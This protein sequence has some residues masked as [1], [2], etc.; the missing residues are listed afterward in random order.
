MGQPT[1]ILVGADKGGVGKTTVARTLLDYLRAH[2]V[3]ARAFDTEPRN[4]T[5]QRFHP[6]ISE[7]VD[8]TSIPG[9]MR[10]FDTL[11]DTA[12]TVFDLRAGLLSSTL[13]ALRDIEFLDSA[14]QGLL[15]FIVFHVVGSS[16][17]SLEDIEY[18]VSS[19]I[20]GK[21]FLVKNFIN[22]TNFFEWDRATYDSFFKKFGGIDE[23]TIPKLREMAYEQVELASV[24]FS[25]FICNKD[26]YGEIASY[27][28]V[29]R[30]YVRHWLGQVWNEYER[31]RLKDIVGGMGDRNVEDNGRDVSGESAET[32]SPALQHAG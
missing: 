5:L 23:V 4:G 20:G 6:E 29:V 10:I 26:K 22:D 8:I 19:T 25:N 15:T 14:K 17:A 21:Y 9:Q 13:R 24:P 28:L 3:P 32:E 18:T 7:I 11:S 31:I 1:I 27:S 12:V 2:E 16:M 30:G